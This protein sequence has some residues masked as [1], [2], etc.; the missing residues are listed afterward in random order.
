MDLNLKL[1]LH[2]HTTVSD[3]SDK[4]E[5]ILENVRNR[6][7]LFKIEDQS[8]F[9]IAVAEL[10]H[11]PGLSTLSAAG[12]EQ[13]FAINFFFPCHKGFHCGS[14]HVYTPVGSWQKP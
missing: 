4:P 2:M 9:K 10:G 13:R 14:F 7:F 6:G 11:Q 12:D 1:D 8:L 5:E 3:G